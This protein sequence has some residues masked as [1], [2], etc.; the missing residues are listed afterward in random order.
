MARVSWDVLLGPGGDL[1]GGFVGRHE[2]LGQPLR[3]LFGR[4]GFGD[5]I[6]P[7]DHR[8]RAGFR[9][10]ARQDLSLQDG[11]AVGQGDRLRRWGL[12]SAVVL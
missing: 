9:L 7:A 1:A 2:N 5:A 3:L 8:A 12:C 10:D 11:L 6:P 4:Q